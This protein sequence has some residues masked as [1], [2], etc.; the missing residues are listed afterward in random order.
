MNPE[1]LGDVLVLLVM[2]F[3]LTGIINRVKALWSGRKGPPLFQPAW[4]VLRL[5]RKK[6]VYSTTTTPLF[7][8]APWVLL[9]TS[10]ASALV[11]PLLGSAPLVTFAFDFVVLAYAWGLG[12]AAVMLAALDTGSSFEGMGAAREAT[13]ATLV[14]PA[15]FLVVGALGLFT[16]SHTLAGALRLHVE[17]GASALAWASAV[18]C[19]LVVLQTETARMP[20]DDPT[21]HLELTMVHEVMVLDHSGPELAAI[22]VAN[23]VKLL[24]GSAVIATLLNPWAGEGS[25][26][27][28]GVTL[29]ASVLVAVVVG[30]IESLIARLKLRTVP[31]YVGVAI[32]AGAIALLATTWHLGGAR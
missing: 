19:L 15:L 5:L 13:F 6:P 14:E 23:G 22:Q 24:V 2:P 20:V 12:R 10:L 8:I 18:V 25:A 16:D 26:V 17:D 21:T 32:A 9:I 27:S 11:T 1:H 29:G 7:R 4:D 30:T 3:L 28:M 31:Q